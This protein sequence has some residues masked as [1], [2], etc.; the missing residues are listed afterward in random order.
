MLLVRDVFRCKPGHAGEVA[1]RLQQTIDSTES[2]DGF[3]SSRVLVDYVSR[4]WTVVME[5]EV[6]SLE[7]F[8]HHMAHYAA[9]PEFRAA[10]EGYTELVLEGYREIFRIL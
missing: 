6:D 2:Q 3:R 5:A 8:E 7:Q 10:M 1:R 4:Y 9:R